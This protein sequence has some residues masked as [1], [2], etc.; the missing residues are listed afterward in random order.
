M[1]DYEQA[2]WDAFVEAEYGGTWLDEHQRRLAHYE[3]V[4]KPKWQARGRAARAKASKVWTEIKG[5]WS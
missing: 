5:A 2:K 3:T 4:V 1:N